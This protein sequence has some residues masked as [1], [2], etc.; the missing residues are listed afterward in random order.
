MGIIE[1]I[2]IKCR[3]RNEK[4]DLALELI[5]EFKKNRVV[6]KEKDI[7]VVS[8]KF[9]AVSQGRIANL[10]KVKVGHE[11]R[12][13]SK[14]Y[15]VQPELSQ[16][17]LEESDS[18]LGGVPGYLLAMSKGILAPNAGIDLSNAPEGFAIMQPSNSENLASE[19]RLRILAHIRSKSISK[20][21]VVLSDSRITPGRLG[22]V[23]I[24]I[25][26]AGIRKTLDMRGA[27]DL[28]RKKLKVTLRAIADQ[29]A[30]AA[31]IV[32]GEA[33][34]AVPVVVIRGVKDAFEKPRTGFEKTSVISEDKCLI[35]SGLRNPYRARSSL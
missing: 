13:L 26:T 15:S 10:S 3:V 35:I 9:A 24:A 19:I 29:L 16:L 28:F 2:P 14:I 1:L 33:D 11:A 27:P 30:T 18:V 32:M 34:E 6:L 7:V 12:H 5:H 20:L 25:A 31:E 23:G 17:V 4:F 22:T 21:G 8:S